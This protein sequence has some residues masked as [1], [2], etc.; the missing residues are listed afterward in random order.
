MNNKDWQIMVEH[1]KSV[2]TQMPQIVVRG[3][4]TSDMHNF[5]RLFEQ[6]DF[7]KFSK[8]LQSLITR[9]FSAWEQPSGEE[10]SEPFYDEPSENP[11]ISLEEL[12]ASLA[13]K[14]PMD[15][16]EIHQRDG[17]HDVVPVSYVLNGNYDCDLAGI[18][19]EQGVYME[20]NR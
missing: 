6:E 14:G 5:E 4:V 16:V 18:T 13:D 12:K 20:V 11:Q 3:N 1:K 2:M 19:N 17:E 10:P 9:V 15:R 8:P 7:S